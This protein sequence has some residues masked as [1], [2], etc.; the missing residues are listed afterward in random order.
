MSAKKVQ[1]QI[2]RR[3]VDDNH[4]Y[5]IDGEYCPGVT[6]IL[7]QAA[8]MAPQLKQYF[9][10]NSQEEIQ[11]RSDESL[12]FGSRIHDAIEKLL[13]GEELNLKDDYKTQKAKQYIMS[14]HDWFHAV[15]PSEYVSEEVIA[16]LKYKYA[17]TLDFAGL[18]STD[19][20]EG[21][22]TGDS[23]KREKKRKDVPSKP[24]LW[25]VDF[26]TSAGIYYNYKLQV[27]AYKQAYEELNNRHVDHVGIVR[28]GTKS[29][30]GYEFEEITED[31]CNFEDFERIYKI[32][33]RLHNGRIP[34]P[35]KMDVYPEKLR[36][37]ERS[38]G[39]ETI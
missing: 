19:R 29:K 11:R 12:T 37:V 1:P 23:L 3:E 17:G 38:K 15:S 20:L 34:Q 10:K 4:Y 33:L 36:I 18:I 7:D 24:E 8:P 6:T 9:I 32:Y 16:S 35:P 25:I 27:M 30:K 22:L 31:E 39:G 13:N 14:F 2:I 21:A 5:F 28:L 26:K